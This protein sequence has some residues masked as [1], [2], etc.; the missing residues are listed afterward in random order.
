MS[1]RDIV[2]RL[3]DA[4]INNYGARLDAADEIERLRNVEAQLANAPED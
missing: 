2:E 3:R 1:K 4:T